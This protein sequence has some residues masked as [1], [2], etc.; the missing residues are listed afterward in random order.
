MIKLNKI[1]ESLIC[2]DDIE[3]II[4]F[5]KYDVDEHYC[6]DEYLYNNKKYNWGLKNAKPKRF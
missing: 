6:I 2:H 3:K 5:T 4:E 1:D